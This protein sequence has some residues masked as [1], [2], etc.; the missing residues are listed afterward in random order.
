MFLE[1]YLKTSLYLEVSASKAVAAKM[2]A[3]LAKLFREHDA[4]FEMPDAVRKAG[5][6]A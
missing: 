5:P 4:K 3:K 6:K 2:A 1:N